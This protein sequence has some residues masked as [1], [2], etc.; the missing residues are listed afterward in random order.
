MPTFT[1]IS[2]LTSYVKEVT[3]KRDIIPVVKIV[4]Q[5]KLNERV[6]SEL[7][8]N[9]ALNGDSEFYDNTF[10]LRN[11]A[12]SKVNEYGNGISNDSNMVSTYVDPDGKYPSHYKGNEDNSKN[13]VKWLND[14]HKGY[15]KGYTINDEGRNFIDKAQK[16]LT[17]GGELKKRITAKL[18]RLG[19]IMSRQSSK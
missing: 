2:Q 5:E 18:K 3:I 11:N 17:T 4:S 19:Y 14:G 6:E 1:T 13:I 16:D 10:G 8:D 9:V 15:Y 12:I 7:Y